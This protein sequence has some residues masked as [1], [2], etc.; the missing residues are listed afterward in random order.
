M[1]QPI[2]LADCGWLR[3]GAAGE[4]NA[5]PLSG[6]NALAGGGG[7]VQL[8]LMMVVMVAPVVMIRVTTIIFFLITPTGLNTV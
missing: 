4:A 7:D 8:T 5:Q 1:R 2:K 6:A 3:A